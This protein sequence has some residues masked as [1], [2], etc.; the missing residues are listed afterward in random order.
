AGIKAYADMIRESGSPSAR[1]F[2]KDIVEWA[3]GEEDYE[4]CTIL[5]SSRSLGAYM[6]E[7]T[8]ILA[9][10]AGVEA[11]GKYGNAEAYR[12]KKMPT[13]KE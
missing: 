10:I 4:Q 13:P 9:T 2:A 8:N 6:R 12:A 1:I 3:A 7:R 11:V 5:K